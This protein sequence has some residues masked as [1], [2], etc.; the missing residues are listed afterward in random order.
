MDAQKVMWVKW[1]MKG[2]QGSWKV[3]QD[4]F[5]EKVLGKYSGVQNNSPY[6]TYYIAVVLS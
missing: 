4:Y 3:Y 5:R 2:E 1:I 6:D